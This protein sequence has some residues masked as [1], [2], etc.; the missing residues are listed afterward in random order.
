MAKEKTQQAQEAETDTENAASFELKE[1]LQGRINNL[2]LSP[3]ANNTLIP[4]FEA[5]SNA[6]HS[7]QERYKRQWAEKGEIIINVLHD[8]EGYPISF[9]I[10]DNGIG[11]NDENFKSFRT[12]DS[13]HKIKKGGKGVGRLTWLKTFEKTEIQ[14]IYR[15]GE[16]KCRRNFA[17]E[18]KNPPINNHKEVIVP[19]GDPQ[20]T[21]V[22]LNQL[23]D[24]YKTSCP[25][26]TDV[27]ARKIIGHFLPYLI[28]EDC[29]G[30]VISDAEKRTDLRELLNENKFNPQSD[31]FE[32]PDIGTFYI[33]HV[34]L[35]RSL[36]EGKAQHTVFF[37][38]HDRIVADHI[39]NNQ[40]G[41]D[42]YFD[43]E[44]KKVAYVG[45]VSGDYLNTNVT[46]ERNNF[47]I[48]SDTFRK[49]EKEA[50]EKAKKYLEVPIA[51]IVEGKSKK[52]ETVLNR[53]PRYKYLVKDSKEFA[54]EL[55]LNARKEEEIY[56]AL[57]V[58]DYRERRETDTKLKSV[59]Q[60]D[61][62]PQ[63]QADFE[64]LFNEILSRIAEQERSSLAEYVVHR[65]A[66]ID[67]LENRLGFED[68]EK[69]S[70]YK[71]DVIHK[72]ICPMR[73]TSSEIDCDQHN[74]WLLDDR[75]AFYDFW[76]SDE[77]I[78]SF[79]KGSDSKDRPDLILFQ[80]CTL[81]H[82]EN[83][84]Q[85]VVIVEFKRPA[86][87]DYTEKENPI[88]QIYK[89][90]KELRD[91]KVNDKNGKLITNINQ[92]TP[93]FCYIVC[94]ITPKLEEFLQD[95]QINNP[96]PGGRGYF[97]Y[98]KTYNA[99]IEIIQ[100]SEIVKDARL[101]HEAFFKELGIN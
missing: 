49:I 6:I 18:L 61:N 39:I 41:L 42:S 74:L 51:E 91:R 72:I 65:K 56:S 78:K 23:K 32:L 26:K 73:A 68:G 96:I 9:S 90:I 45:I 33:Q 36:M 17:F 58:Q 52:V 38:A 12:Y 15:K 89:Y 30:I 99:Y 94:D 63:A 13:T 53:F 28:V 95:D 93:F 40:T 27:I 1:D 4:L 88:R 60:S 66:V 85:P 100:Y 48:D 57:S 34:L 79:A 71:E 64:A 22:Y 62:T 87:E 19:L 24:R 81:L 59:L 55:P 84:N 43:Y 46:Q 86:R 101:R 80:G 3:N 98:H 14:S 31:E 21:S 37:A 77:N 67:L 47:D 50:E 25:Q 29:P 97:G 10:E 76:A 35:D 83:T 5:I 20:I 11:L 70:K 82:R 2:A 16:K 7:I 75:L 92:N 44:E 8:Q 54:K 69:E